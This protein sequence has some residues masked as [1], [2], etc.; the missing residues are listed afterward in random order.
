[1]C[2]PMD[3]CYL[4]EEGAHEEAWRLAQEL[5]GFSHIIRMQLFHEYELRKILDRY[6]YEEAKKIVDKFKQAYTE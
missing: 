4:L 3:Y 1:M 2:S 5:S 6:S